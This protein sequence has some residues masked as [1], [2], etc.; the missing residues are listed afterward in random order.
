MWIRARKES[1]VKSNCVA[2]LSL[3]PQPRSSSWRS[4]LLRGTSLVFSFSCRPTQIRKD[5]GGDKP[6]QGVS[7][8]IRDC[9]AGIFYRLCWLDGIGIKRGAFSFIFQTLSATTPVNLSVCCCFFHP[10]L[11]HYALCS[12]ADCCCERFIGLLAEF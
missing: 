5:L 3:P 6:V 9:S 2:T 10:P 8:P 12:R 1:L 11:Q 4:I 7:K